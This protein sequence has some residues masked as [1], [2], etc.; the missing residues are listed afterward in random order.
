MTTPSE[1]STVGA[2]PEEETANTTC[3]LD[4]EPLVERIVVELN[5]LGRAATFEFTLAVGS[6]IVNRLYSGDLQIWRNRG[7]KCASFRSLTKHPDLPMSA[8]SL[9]RCVAIYELCERLGIRRWRHISTSHLRLVLPLPPR[10]QER[11][12]KAAETGNWPVRHLRAEIAAISDLEQRI[13]RR[14]GGRKRQSSIRR[15]IRT[16]DHCIDA[17]SNLLAQPDDGSPESHHLVVTAIERMH[18]VCERL[19]HRFRQHTPGARTEPP[20]SR[21]SRPSRSE[22]I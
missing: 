14:R 8:G 16:I 3:D 17:C 6:L 4:P 9:Y 5:T 19:E 21:C 1:Q 20:P 11:L 15:T 7:V 10:D 22:K 2:S 18:A 12:L 13:D